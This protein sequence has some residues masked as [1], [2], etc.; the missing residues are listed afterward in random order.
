MPHIFYVNSFFL[1]M[2][3]IVPNSNIFTGM[4]F[5]KTLVL[6]S[7][8]LTF[9][10]KSAWFF[11]FLK[12]DNLT[13]CNNDHLQLQCTA[14]TVL[15]DTT[16]KT[17]TKFQGGKNRHHFTVKPPYFYN[18]KSWKKFLNSRQIEGLEKYAYVTEID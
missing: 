14:R 2:A 3:V 10:C 8:I 1:N 5:G 17:S 11:Q 15:Q 4:V 9:L 7:I 12:F 6:N 18:S 13:V 16:N